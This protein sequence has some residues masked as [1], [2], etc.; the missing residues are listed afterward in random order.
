MPKINKLHFNGADYDIGDK[1]IH[2][3]TA[4]STLADNDEFMIADSADSYWH[5]KVTMQDITDRIVYPTA[6][7]LIVWWWGW[8]GAACCKAEWQWW[9]GWAVIEEHHYLLGWC[10]ISVVVGAWWAWWCAADSCCDWCNWWNSC[11]WTLIANWG[12]G[13][14]GKR[15]ASATSYSQNWTS[16]SWNLWWDSIALAWSWW[17]WN[18][19][20]WCR[21]AY[22]MCAASAWQFTWWDWW[23]G[24]ASNMTWQTAVYWWWWGWGWECV[25]WYWQ[26]WWGNWWIAWHAWCAWTNWTWWWWGWGWQCAAAYRAW[27]NGWSWVVVIRYWENWECGINCATWGTVTCCNWYIIHTFTSDWTFCIVN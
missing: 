8:W 14:W 18:W 3:L 15:N 20:R 6:D 21:W 25:Y 19:S 27:W 17:G 12:T 7:I 24:S 1:D 10:S 11:F 23:A 4:K 13:G 5:K 22:I 9:W 16:W 2:D 26:W